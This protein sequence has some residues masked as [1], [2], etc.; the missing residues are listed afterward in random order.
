MRKVKRGISLIIVMMILLFV[1]ALYIVFM[2]FQL[3]V[4]SPDA[5]IKIVSQYIFRGDMGNIFTW[6]WLTVFIVLYRFVLPGACVLI[7][8][9]LNE[10]RS[11]RLE[12]YLGYLELFS[13]LFMWAML[14][15]LNFLS[16]DIAG[17]YLF[18]PLAYE[19]LL[20][21][22]LRSE[23]VRAM[24]SASDALVYSL[25]RKSVV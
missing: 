10:Y 20:L 24:P 18:Y 21:M 3:I 4:I 8:L 17:F 14:I 2:K 5:G 11:T 13:V 7:M 12:R 23:S 15:F 9:L 1:F 6:T 19:F 16:Q 25:D 22:L